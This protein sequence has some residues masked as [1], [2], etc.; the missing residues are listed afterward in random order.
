MSTDEY[1]LSKSP[2]TERAH[3]LWLQHAAGFVLM[4]DIRGY[5][6]R[7]IAP[8]ASPDARAAAERAIDDALYGLMMIVDGVTGHLHNQDE[9][10]AL[11][12]L[13]QLI[14]RS[15]AGVEEVVSEVDLGDGDGMCMGYHT[16]CDNDFGDHEVATVRR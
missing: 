14:R 15:D 1:V 8:D 16:W 2:S 6:R 4:Q 10:V 7:R 11:K 3:E 9:S 12:L 5:A 13:V